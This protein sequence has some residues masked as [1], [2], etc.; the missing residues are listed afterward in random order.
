M[1]KCLLA[2]LAFFWIGVSAS[3][4][5]VTA[6]PPNEEPAVPIDLEI[7]MRFDD[8]LRL[9]DLQVLGT[10]NSYKQAIPPAEFA[11]IKATAGDR[12]D[13]LDYFHA[14]LEEQ[15]DQG[16]RQLEIDLYY[17]PAGGLLADPLLARLTAGQEGARAFDPTSLRAPGFK[18]LHAHDIDVWS[19]CP[20]L[21]E[22][23]K[24]VRDWSTAHP[25]H[26]PIMIVLEAK[27]RPNSVP[28]SI[29]PLEFDE[30]A[31]TAVDA[32]IRSVFDA[33]HMITPDDV[34]GDYPTLR[35]AVLDGAWPTL[36]EARGKVL[37]TLTRGTSRDG[38]YQRGKENLEGLIAFP[39]VEDL[40]APEAA[41]VGFGNP[42]RSMERIQD[43][44][45]QGFLVRTR[46]D[47]G[48][49]EARTNDTT[50]SQAALVSGAQYVSTDYYEPRL[51]WSTYEVSLPGRVSARISPAR[52]APGCVQDIRMK[53]KP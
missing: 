36:G 4:S 34:R 14:P 37:F 2:G 20:T 17:D 22:C 15:L 25:S 18:V 5:E 50:R 53:Q 42:V 10:H 43:A 49:N 46:A 13:A 27:Q 28:G 11:L 8:C 21:I 3:M 38:H 19:H 41:F 45:A 31:W 7:D 9:N 35:D 16:I 33:N 1:K 30:K 6:Q 51:E 40:S 44:V 29:T 24:T 47:A 26:V 12:A 32:E 23:L 52:P 48:T 39:H